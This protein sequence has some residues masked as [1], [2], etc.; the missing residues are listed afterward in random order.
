MLYYQITA[1]LILL[2]FY[3]CYIIKM[4]NQKKQGIQTDRLGKG[5]TGFPKMIEIVL[6]ISS[7]VIVIADSI[8]I[9]CCQKILFPVVSIGGLMVSAL[10]TGIFIKA[11]T[12]MKNNWR[13][14]VCEKDK[15]ELVTNGIYGW[16][17]N[18]AFLGFDLTYIGILT[19]FF[20]ITL[21]II[22]V[23]TVTI[24]HLQIV[25]VEEDFLLD[26]FGEEYLHYKKSVNRYLG[27]KR[28]RNF[29]L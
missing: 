7:Y 20:N 26:R 27:K 11:V 2:T 16:S 22:T 29:S 13:A 25:N 12:D 14:G 17:R 6:K 28:N 1:F 19:A 5:K 24:F 9:I 4:L 21:L 3:S 23:I 10:G 8:S 15:T 18:P